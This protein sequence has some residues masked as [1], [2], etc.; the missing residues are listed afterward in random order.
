MKN[1]ADKHVLEIEK[2]TG[3]EDDPEVSKR[4]WKTGAEEVSF[5]LPDGSER[6]CWVLSVLDANGER[7]CFGKSAD[8]NFIVEMENTY[9]SLIK[10]L[11]NHR[12]S[13][14]AEIE[15]IKKFKIVPKTKA[16]C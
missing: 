16:I 8:M 14:D 7:V 10:M 2:K 13:C 6:K 4:P 11:E 15:K 12:D 9:N 5:L 1:K 3:I